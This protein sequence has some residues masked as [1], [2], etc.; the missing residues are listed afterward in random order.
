MNIDY[1]VWATIAVM[2]AVAV[3]SPGPDFA[4]VLK[5][6][7]QKGLRPALWTS[8]G[9]ACGI[10]L[11]VAYSILGVS[12]VIRSTPWLYQIL[13]Y[14]AA[15]YFLYIGLSALRSQPQTA[16]TSTSEQDNEGPKARSTWYRAFGL[17]FLVNG[18][19]PKATLFFLALFTAAIPSS[20]ALATQVFYGV[21]LALATG[22][23][24]CFLSLITNIQKIR[25]AYQRQGHWFDRIMGLVL[26]IMAV[27]LVWQ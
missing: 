6:G 3:I 25:L 11:H 20:T 16:K 26:I 23:W 24:F 18:L 9:I 2:H 13:L 14:V 4:V 22:I 8:F 10:L 7:L 19:N 21:Y 5:Q 12:I 15:G 1:T 27:I 17:G